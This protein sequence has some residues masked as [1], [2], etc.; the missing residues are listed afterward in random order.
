M[1]SKNTAEKKRVAKKNPGTQVSG[2]SQILMLLFLVWDVF[3]STNKNRNDRNYRSNPKCTGKPR[4]V[5]VKRKSAET[6]QDNQ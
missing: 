4:P 1:C 5:K 2:R 6:H 3:S